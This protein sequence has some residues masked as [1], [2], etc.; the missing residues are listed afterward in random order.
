MI[1]LHRFGRSKK[2]LRDQ[3]NFFQSEIQTQVPPHLFQIQ[4][5]Q[6]ELNEIAHAQK[7]IIL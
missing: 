2:S 1:H 5:H 7:Y 4:A 3:N 6:I